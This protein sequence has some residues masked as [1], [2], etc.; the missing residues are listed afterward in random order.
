MAE[1]E[2]SRPTRRAAFTLALVVETLF[3]LFGLMTFAHNEVAWPPGSSGGT[4]MMSVTHATKLITRV[5][6]YACFPDAVAVRMRDGIELYCIRKKVWAARQREN[7]IM[8][9]K[10]IKV[11]PPGLF[12]DVTNQPRQ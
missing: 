1:L 10:N 12:A 5:R 2:A 11:P 9:K 3:A 7:K 4:E 6:R 8:G